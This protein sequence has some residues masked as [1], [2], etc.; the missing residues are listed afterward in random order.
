M[1]RFKISFLKP[2]NPVAAGGHMVH[3]TVDAENADQA[4][5]V[6]WKNNGAQSYEIQDVTDL[7]PEPDTPGWNDWSLWEK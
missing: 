5:K 4:K 3:Y 7:P 1:R 2:F 6:A